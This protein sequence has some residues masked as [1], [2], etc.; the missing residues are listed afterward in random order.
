MATTFA[1]QLL[2]WHI[3]NPRPLPWDGGPRDAYH[4]WVSEIIMQQT[5]IE[6]G[7]PYYLRFIKRFPTIKQLATA[8]IDEVLRYWQGLGYY[9]RARNLHKAAQIIVNDLGGVFPSTHEALM[10]LPGVGEYTAAAIASFAFNLPH[11]VVDGN[12]KRLLARFTGFTTSID[13]SSSHQKIVQL[14]TQLM[15]EKYPAEFNQAIMNFGALVCTPKNPFCKTCPLSKKCYALNNN[16]V[17]DLPVRTKKKTNTLRY[18]HFLVLSWKG[19]IL[20]H[21][22]GGKDIWHGLYTPPILETKSTRKPSL[23]SFASE[24]LVLTGTDKIQWVDSSDAIIQPLS[25]QTLHGRFYHIELLEKPGKPFPD[26][27]WVSKRQMDDF[28]KPKMVVEGEI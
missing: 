5:R 23:K 21:Q 1:R 27:V 22:R 3:K 2:Q 16:C 19:K 6:Q 18:F 20:L 4:I 10:K 8:P 17:E 25:H 9:S 13:E 24:I 26:Y 28:P 11:P 15:Q 14:A 7:G 12:V